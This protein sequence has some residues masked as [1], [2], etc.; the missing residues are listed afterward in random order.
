MMHC[1]VCGEDS[2]EIQVG[3]WNRHVHSECRDTYPLA[4]EY[5][6]RYQH[7]DDSETDAVLYGIEIACLKL[8]VEFNTEV[9]TTN[10][11]LEQQDYR[12]WRQEYMKKR[13]IA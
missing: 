4:Q 11:R 10:L 12:E 13:G 3:G 9:I 2:A 6:E 8:G 1:F 7:A 5:A